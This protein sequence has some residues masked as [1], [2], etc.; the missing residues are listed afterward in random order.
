MKYLKNALCA[1]MVF[2]ML[3]CLTSCGTSRLDH[4]KLAQ[5]LDK[6]EETYGRDIAQLFLSIYLWAILSII[7]IWIFLIVQFASL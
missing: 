2:V 7:S 4:K 3:L 6:Q 1:A 5:F